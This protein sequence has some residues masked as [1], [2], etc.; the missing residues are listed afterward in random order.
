MDNGFIKLKLNLKGR[1]KVSEARHA[2]E[3]TSPLL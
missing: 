3:A 1:T 2:I